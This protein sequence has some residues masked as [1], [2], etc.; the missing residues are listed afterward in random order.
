MTD[1]EFL[2]QAEAE[3]RRS[4]KRVVSEIIAIG[5]KLSEIKDRVGHGR[6][7]QF[8]R[9]RLWFS[10]RTAQQ[11]V[12]SYEF[13]KSA[14]CADFESLHIDPSALRLLARSSTPN[15]VRLEALER[16]AKPEGISFSEVKK[17]IGKTVTGAKAR[18][19]RSGWICDEFG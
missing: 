6:Y 4:G 17:L 16:A 12:Q 13:L 14:H 5:R 19:E 3:I 11:F 15:E 7:G 8:V 10:E 1:E 18:A 2:N 9:E